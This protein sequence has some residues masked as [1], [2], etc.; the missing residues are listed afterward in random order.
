MQQEVKPCKIADLSECTE[1]TSDY[2][3]LLHGKLEGIF[4]FLCFNR[5]K[6]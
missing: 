1:L 4:S 6:F 5:G 3:P 2:S